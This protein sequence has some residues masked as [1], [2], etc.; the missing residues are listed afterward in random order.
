MILWRWRW[1]LRKKSRPT[2]EALGLEPPIN[3]GE[4]RIVYVN[5]DRR[6]DR[7]KEIE[8]EFEGLGIQHAER[9]SAIEN[10]DG[11]LGCA[12]SH[13]A[14]LLLIGGEDFRPTLICEDDI[15]F[16][17]PRETIESVVDEFLLNPLLDVLCLGNALIEKPKKIS[18]QLSI[19]NNVQTTSCYL[20]KKEAVSP[21]VEVAQ[22]SVEGL[23]AGRDYG[24][25]A[26]DQVWKSLQQGR[27]IFAVPNTRLVRQRSSYSDIEKK[28]VS[29]KS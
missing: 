18:P 23:S 9:F 17:A 8:K 2:P 14:C 7:K 20:V 24:R 1:F 11:G 4:L 13:T 5:L 15:E 12:K 26:Y 28:I 10:T 3:L 6:R 25:Y 22:K 21:L 29:Y 16:L 19:S 27:L